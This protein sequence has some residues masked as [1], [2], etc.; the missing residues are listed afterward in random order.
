MTP[1]VISPFFLMSD[2]VC[3]KAVVAEK[4]NTAARPETSIA[5][6]NAKRIMVV[7]S[8]ET[9]FYETGFRQHLG[10]SPR[11]VLPAPNGCSGMVS[12]IDALAIQLFG[13]VSGKACA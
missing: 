7:S 4:T 6:R 2:M 8:V 12:T 5:R 1:T 13:H 11:C 3:A 10:I 9:P